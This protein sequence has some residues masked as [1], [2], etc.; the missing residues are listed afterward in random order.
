MEVNVD[1]FPDM[2]MMP[3]TS[4]FQSEAEDIARIDEEE[5]EPLN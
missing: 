1:Y 4:E 2:E 3:Q 5:E